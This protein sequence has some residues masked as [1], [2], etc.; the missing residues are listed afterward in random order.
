[1]SLQLTAG[2][3]ILP[4]SVW[5]FLRKLYRSQPGNMKQYIVK[6]KSVDH[7][8][9]DVLQIVTEKPQDYTFNPGQATEIAINKAGWKD[10]KRPFTFT[11]LPDKDLLEFTIKTYP[12]HK[13]SPT[14]FFI[15]KRMMN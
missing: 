5:L 3:P 4:D 1:M 12:S 7:I 13:V 6:I 2:I 11:S 8:T 10:K 14:N 9:H 15:L